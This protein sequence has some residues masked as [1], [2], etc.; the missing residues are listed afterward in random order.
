MDLET[1]PLLGLISSFS[2][3]GENL[4]GI[5]LNP[6]LT[7]QLG[8]DGD[9][10]IP[11]TITELDIDDDWLIGRVRGEIN[12]MAL[13]GLNTFETLDL[14]VPLSSDQMR[15]GVAV[16]YG[17]P[18]NISLAAQFE[19]TP[20]PEEGL[21]LNMLSGFRS[22][23][24]TLSQFTHSSTLDQ[25]SYLFQAVTKS[26]AAQNGGVFGDTPFEEDVSLSILVRELN[27]TLEAQTL[28][29]SAELGVLTLD[30]IF[31]QAPCLFST[32]DRLEL[33]QGN[34]SIGGIDLQMKG[35]ASP[36]ILNFQRWV[37]GI[38]D[39]L[40]EIVE[41]LL[42]GG[43][44]RITELV[45]EVLLDVLWNAP[46]ECQG[47]NAPPRPGT[48]LERSPVTLATVVT[49]SVGIV[50]ALSVF[51]CCTRSIR[52]RCRARS[53]KLSRRS[54]VDNAP[55]LQSG[56][57][58]IGDDQ[59]ALV[60]HPAVS[61]LT[62]Y[63]IP[64]ALFGNIFIFAWAHSSVGATLNAEIAIGNRPA[65][66]LP[67]LFGF[68]LLDTIIDL[69]GA[70]VYFLSLLVAIFSG[71]WPYVK[72]IIMTIAWFMKPVYLPPSKREKVLAAMDAFG[73][74]SLIDAVV[75]VLLMVAFRFSL[76]LPLGG[77]EARVDVIVQ[78]KVGFYALQAATMLSLVLGHIIAYN[79]RKARGSFSTTPGGAVESIA[80]HTF[81][82]SG[83]RELRL[84][85]FGNVVVI[86][87]MLIALTFLLMGST[88]DSFI[89]DFDGL[90]GAVL[91]D[92]KES[93]FSLIS[94]GR[95][96]PDTSLDPNTVGIR[97]IQSF[98]YIFGMVMPTVHL[99]VCMV[100]W[101]TPMTISKMRN[102]YIMAEI[103]N[104]WA[105]IDVLVL[106][107]L[108]AMLQIGQFVKFMIGSNCDEINI[109]LDIYL[110]NSDELNGNN[111]CFDV[112]GRLTNGAFWLLSCAVIYLL[113]AQPMMVMM[114]TAV[115]ERLKNSRVKLEPEEDDDDITL[116]SDD[117]L[118]DTTSPYPIL[119]SDSFTEPR[120]RLRKKEMSLSS[121]T[122]E[123][124]LQLMRV[125][126]MVT[127]RG[128][129]YEPDLETKTSKMFT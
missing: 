20:P 37:N 81:S 56:S 12:G 14:L 105:A 100:V 62:R 55:L 75:L 88:L 122:L 86:F 23:L 74:Y 15:I 61:N 9:V 87:Y 60:A 3:E 76:V 54:T 57:M 30:Q 77:S 50:L 110:Y 94:L 52:K 82:I 58:M 45:N 109:F 13:A 18:L 73:K 48:E 27:L 51:W 7:C 31:S 92:T 33:L 29:N 25:A 108:A 104:G 21:I 127:I 89:F 67:D 28:V 63:G 125:L 39:E 69:W 97:S 16:G 120:Q 72:L 11:G 43:S 129:L 4:L 117:N 113:V 99:C 5:G 65:L 71:L 101:L 114:H 36:S 91:G 124:L 64:V 115:E 53:R 40:S 42:T 79:A 59:H 44:E 2:A 8:E 90:A 103:L 26:F 112:T 123:G 95:V 98:Y 70:E 128:A 111:V 68:G 47:A 66:F 85:T 1:D 107:I 10:D 6:I 38:D 116:D 41:W 93:V 19:Y 121:K 126:R 24:M 32:I 106:G 80:A 119:T 49:T 102:T 34:G 96:L 83:D 22:D 46:F 17:R 118:E 35:A 84:T 78:P